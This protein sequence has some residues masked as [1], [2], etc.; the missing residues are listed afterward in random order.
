MS[1]IAGSWT[2]A[3]RHAQFDFEKADRQL[4]FA[5][6]SGLSL[7][8]DGRIDDR[9]RL[10][11]ALTQAGASI[12]D[13][14][15]DAELVLCAYRAWGEVCVEQILGDFAF[16][17]WDESQQR[18]FCAR[19]RFGVR[20]FYYAK[21]TDRFLFANDLRVLL[22][23]P[24]LSAELDESAL[25]DFLLF[26]YDR[27]SAGTSFKA[28]RQLPPAHA[29]SVRALEH[30]LTRYWL[31]APETI[32]HYRDPQQ[33]IEQFRDIFQV[34]VADRVRE[35]HIGILLSGGMDSTAV[36]AYAAPHATL[37]GYTVT[38]ERLCP[39]DVEGHYARLAAQSLGFTTTLHGIDEIE[40]FERWHEASPPFMA[41][42]YNPYQSGH[43]DLLKQAVA[44]GCRVLLSGDG[45]DPLMLAAPGYCASLLRN[46]RWGRLLGELRGARASR[47]HLR[48]M[49]L[50]GVL[51]LSGATPKAAPEFPSWLD[52]AL[53][54]RQGLRER[55]RAY[56]APVKPTTDRAQAA[57]VDMADTAWYETRFRQDEGAGAP[58]V[59][60]YPFFD[61]RVVE[62]LLA[63]PQYLVTEKWIVR[64]ALSN[65]L[66]E[67]ITKRRKT[68]F[69]G[70]LLKPWLLRNGSQLNQAMEFRQCGGLVD[71]NN[72][73]QAISRYCAN[74]ARQLPWDSIHLAGPIA[75]ARWLANLQNSR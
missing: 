46:G 21:L 57:L 75:L 54:Q 37:H 5:E 45:G 26:G 31:P 42:V 14:T 29:L 16:A 20:P 41:P 30:R 38:A 4:S 56:Y 53:V 48:G 13:A 72:Y 70:D 35:P 11:A 73:A 33:Y 7:V 61:A 1:V 23:D 51:S 49:G 71:D 19:D 27:N 24:N 44:D 10:H 55:W 15:A 52:S 8:F 47:G 36:A 28:I 59:V 17:V 58:V 9:R 64:Q 22:G 63:L 18:L 34:A 25:A 68:P 12:D 3:L 74:S 50:R 40:P 66:P 43:D 67:E 32:P 69:Q 39:G 65:R 2:F 6:L 60:R 62:F